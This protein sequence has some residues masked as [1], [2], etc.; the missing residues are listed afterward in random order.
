[1]EKNIF[2]FSVI[3]VGQIFFCEGLF[4]KQK[5]LKSNQTN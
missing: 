2:I 4:E 5:K 1:M 3:L